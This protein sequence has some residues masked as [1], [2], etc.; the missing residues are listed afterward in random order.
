[1][2]DVPDGALAVRHVVDLKADA[3]FV[4]AASGDY[5]RAIADYDHT[6]RWQPHNVSCL[7]NRGSA[8]SNLRN[9]ARAIAD[10]KEAARINPH[11]QPATD[12]LTRAVV[13]QSQ[14]TST[15][16]A[17]GTVSDPVGDAQPWPGVNTSPDLV[18][19]N[20]VAAGG[21]LAM[22]IRFASGTFDPET[23]QILID[24][25]V[26]QNPSTGLPGFYPHSFDSD[27]LGTDYMMDVIS[28]GRR[29]NLH[30]C[31]GIQGNGCAAV[32]STVID[33]SPNEIGLSV[34][35]PIL[36]SSEGRV[37]FKVC[38]NSFVQGA[39]YTPYLDCVPDKGLPPAASA[40]Q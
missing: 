31:A 40:V 10:F 21:V 18:S 4:R 30:Q 14:E 13:S 27:V 23:T 32:Y 2:A 36:H 39:G 35:L 15:E 19:A 6:L 28:H 16:E 26:D 5:E 11:Y 12:L 7:V 24:F 29:A 9:R 3:V 34:P 37:N 1:M 20:A 8:Y 22:H 33:V 38:V 17:E 25:D